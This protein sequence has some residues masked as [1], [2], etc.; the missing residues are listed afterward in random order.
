MSKSQAICQIIVPGRKHF[1]SNF[2][3]I[4]HY[5][6]KYKG[7]NPNAVLNGTEQPNIIMC[8]PLHSCTIV[9]GKKA[10]SK[11]FL[12]TAIPSLLYC[13]LHTIIEN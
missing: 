1:Q 7:F 2:K 13:L 9:V 3:K 12:W 4:K 5:Y 10:W 6:K 8:T 11:A